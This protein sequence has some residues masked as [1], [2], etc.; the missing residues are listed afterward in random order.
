MSSQ[1]SSSQANQLFSERIILR[2]EEDL[3]KMRNTLLLLLLGVCFSS[4]T[5]QFIC[6]FS[7][8]DNTSAFSQ[9]LLLFFCLFYIPYNLFIIINIPI[10]VTFQSK[11]YP[12]YYIGVTG[13][14]A[15]IV[16]RVTQWEVVRGLCGIQGTISFKSRTR[17][18]YLRHR[19]FKLYEDPF[20][21]TPLYRNDACFYFHWNSFFPGYYSFESVNY[22]NFYIRHSFF[23]LFIWRHFDTQL[24]KNDAS[25]KA[26]RV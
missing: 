22:R 10:A 2:E 1:T 7:F 21:D 17:N 15:K 8:E 11:N 4:V 19:W 14:E 12:S 20:T 16:N 3:M 5:A 6:E 18:A 24:F 23:R 9:L 25:F 26:T 13:N